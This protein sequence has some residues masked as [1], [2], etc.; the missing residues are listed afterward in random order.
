MTPRVIVER[1]RHEEMAV[2]EEMTGIRQRLE[3]LEQRLAE[4]AITRRTISDL[5][6]GDSDG[7]PLG[8]DEDGS[9]KAQ[10]PSK[11]ES[12]ENAPNTEEDQAEH[13]ERKPRGAVS[14]RMVMLV[15][16][17]DRPLRAREVAIALGKTEPTRGQVEASPC[18]S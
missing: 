10:Q 12:S 14:Q 9:A 15:G 3:A 7:Q 16:S 17:S 6:E 4:L 13:P 1:L 11:G 2:Q 5:L 18:S 8:T